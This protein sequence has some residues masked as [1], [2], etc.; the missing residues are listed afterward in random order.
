MLSKN[1]TIIRFSADSWSTDVVFSKSDVYL[2][3]CIHAIAYIVRACVRACK[4]QFLE[5]LGVTRCGKDSLGPSER[6]CGE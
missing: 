2:S 3:L 6:F 5:N 1:S 4:L